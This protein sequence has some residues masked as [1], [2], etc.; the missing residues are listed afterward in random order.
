MYDKKIC[1]QGE[2]DRIPK[3]QVGSQGQWWNKVSQIIWLKYLVCDAKTVVNSEKLK[4]CGLMDG[5]G[6]VCAIAVST[7]SSGEMLMDYK[8]HIICDKLSPILGNDLNKKVVP[9]CF[10]QILSDIIREGF[11]SLGYWQIFAQIEPKIFFRFPYLN[12]N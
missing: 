8:Q 3:S 5:R 7:E 10:A 4:F 6:C 9:S 11:F 1:P 2:Q 12:R